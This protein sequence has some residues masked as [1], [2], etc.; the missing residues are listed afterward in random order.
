[1]PTIW[2]SPAVSH[3]ESCQAAAA[4]R[5]LPEV[6]SSLA[7]G[8]RLLHGH[9]NSNVMIPPATALWPGQ[10]SARDC[11]GPVFLW[12]VACRVGR[13]RRASRQAG[14]LS[15]ACAGRRAGRWSRRSPGSRSEKTRQGGC[16]GAGALAG[17]C[18]LLAGRAG[19]WNPLGWRYLVGL[20]HPLLGALPPPLALLPPSNFSIHLPHLFSSRG[21]HTFL[22]LLPRSGP[23]ETAPLRLFPSPSPM[24]PVSFSRLNAHLM[25]PVY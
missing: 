11:S 18:W 10:R 15:P 17:R 5:A 12:R 14:K 25:T 21:H 20:F 3:G 1:M 19:R 2:P 24:F 22:H 16:A 4:R 13:L 6:P 23:P 8:G 9:G 7:A